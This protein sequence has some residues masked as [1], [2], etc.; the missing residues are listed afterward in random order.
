[1]KRILL[2]MSVAALMVAMIVATVM[3]VFAKSDNCA[4]GFKGTGNAGQTQGEAAPGQVKKLPPPPPPE[5]DVV[6]ED[7]CATAET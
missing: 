3:P 2:V 7:D 1:M 5:C 6:E 4:T